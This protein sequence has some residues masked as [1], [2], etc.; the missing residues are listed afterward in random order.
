MTRR[1]ENLA[2][3]YFDIKKH[4]L[5]SPYYH[6]ILSEETK[7]QLLDFTEQEL[8]RE[9][10]WVILNSGMKENVIRGLFE[11]FSNS[12]MNWDSA[13]IIVRNKEECYEKAMKVFAHTGKIKAICEIAYLIFI[14][15][16][17]SFKA[18]IQR[19][20]IEFISSLPYLGSVTGRHLLKNLG[21]D[22]IKP[23]RH[24][25]RIAEYFGYS[26]PEEMCSELSNVIDEKVSVIDI[27]LWRFANSNRN[28]LNY[29]ALEIE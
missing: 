16:V 17:D 5:S 27:V 2:N 20:G 11:R 25:I 22:V 28:Y 23:D 18:K 7:N 4:L 14:E 12:F 6:E 26:S 19:D 8:L 13:S 24:L 29:L 3:A 9:I 1:T 15:G 21:Y 10:A